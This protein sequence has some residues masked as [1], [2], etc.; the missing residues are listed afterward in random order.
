MGIVR[1]GRDWGR[2]GARGADF[3]RRRWALV[4]GQR[5]PVP[6]PTLQIWEDQML[7]KLLEPLGILK[8]TIQVESNSIDGSG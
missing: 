6:L 3:A 5:P 8:G 7:L 1:R 4:A 2:S